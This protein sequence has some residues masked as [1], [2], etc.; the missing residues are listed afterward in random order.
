MR[1]VRR[2][3]V[4][5]HNAL[6]KGGPLIVPKSF[7]LYVDYQKCLSTPGTI[8]ELWEQ[9]AKWFSFSPGPFIKEFWM[10]SKTHKIQGPGTLYNTDNSQRR[11]E[12]SSPTLVLNLHA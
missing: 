8:F 1:Q 2:D 7:K 4:V 12:T 11:S 6:K 5:K 9:I 10:G 3:L